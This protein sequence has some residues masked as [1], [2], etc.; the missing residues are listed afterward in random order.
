MAL[1]KLDTEIRREQIIEAALSL[2]AAQG[3]RQLSV[4]ALARRVGLVPSALYR[5]FKSKQ[6]ILQAAVQHIRGKVGENLKEV[7]ASTPNALERLELVLMRVVKMIRELQAM[8]R[9]VFAEGI[10]DQPEPKRYAYE[11]LK[12]V[13]AELESIMRQGQERGEVRSDLDAASLAVMFWSQ[14]P[15]LV[16]LWQMSDGRFDV[17]HQAERSWKL[18]QEGI[19]AR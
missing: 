13:L 6:E 14:I 11:M 16:I 4:A 19:Q 12:G 10:S 7:C 1:E 8:P 3:V 18:F 2:I 17:T 9:I 15:A 5:H